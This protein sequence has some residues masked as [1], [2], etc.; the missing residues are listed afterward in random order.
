MERVRSLKPRRATIIVFLLILVL[1]LAAC[2]ARES[3]VENVVA[4]TLTA[5]KS[6]ADA[7]NTSV[8]ATMQAA[9]TATPVPVEE[10]EPPAPVVEE[11]SATP[12][13]E[14][15]ESEF[16]PEPMSDASL[17]GTAFLE[18]DRFLVT[19][20]KS[21]VFEAESEDEAYTLLVNGHEFKCEILNENRFRIYC[22]GQPI[23]PSGQIPVSLLAVDGSCPY[24]LPFETIPVPQKPTPEPTG[25]YD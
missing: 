5:E 23:P 25:P 9:P 8:A 4:A 18:G 11:A 7:V 14:P 20:Q 22:H 13:P 6:K 3:E 24:Q 1:L 21:S 12:S 17:L 19:L 10:T 15:E 2:G 16:C